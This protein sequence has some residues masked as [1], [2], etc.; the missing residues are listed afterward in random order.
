G[1]ESRIRDSANPVKDPKTLWF[2][3]LSLISAIIP[4]ISTSFSTFRDWI[5]AQKSRPL[6]YN[7]T[8]CY[9]CCILL[10]SLRDLFKIQNAVVHSPTTYNMVVTL[11]AIA[12]DDHVEVFLEILFEF[13]FELV[14][15]D[16]L[17]SNPGFEN[18]LYSTSFE[19]LL[20]RFPP[21]NLSSHS[22]ELL[23]HAVTDETLLEDLA[24]EELVPTFVDLLANRL[25][26]VVG[27]EMGDVPAPLHQFPLTCNSM[28]VPTQSAPHVDTNPL[29]PEIR[30][31]FIPIGSGIHSNS[32]FSSQQISRCNIY[33]T[34]PS[35]G[36]LAPNETFPTYSTIAH[37]NDPA[38]RPI[39]TAVKSDYK[40]DI[41]AIQRSPKSGFRQNALD[42]P[43]HVSG[44]KNQLGNYKRGVHQGSTLYLQRAPQCIVDSTLTLSAFVSDHSM[45]PSFRKPYGSPHSVKGPTFLAV[46][47]ASERAPPNNVN[48]I[49]PKAVAPQDTEPLHSGISLECSPRPMITIQSAMDAQPRVVPMVPYRLSTLQP[50]ASCIHEPMLS[51]P[52]TISNTSPAGPALPCVSRALVYPGSAINSQIPRCPISHVP[53]SKSSPPNGDVSRETTCQPSDQS[54]RWSVSNHLSRSRHTETTHVGEDLLDGGTPILVDP[55]SPN[56]L[57]QDWSSDSLF[58]SDNEEDYVDEPKG[59]FYHEVGNVEYNDDGASQCSE[60]FGI[61][62][63]DSHCTEFDGFMDNADGYDDSIDLHG[64]GENYDFGSQYEYGDLEDDS[65]VQICDIGYN[66]DETS[67]HSDEPHISLKDSTHLEVDE[68]GNAVLSGEEYA[69]YD[70]GASLCSDKLGSP[71]DEEET[72]YGPEDPCEIEQPLSDD[73]GASQGS[74]GGL[75][76][77]RGNQLDIDEEDTTYLYDEAAE[78]SDSQVFD[79]TG[80]GD[81]PYGDN[82]EPD[83][84]LVLVPQH[85]PQSLWSLQRLKTP[86]CSP[87]LKSD[88]YYPPMIQ[89]SVDIILAN[90]LAFSLLGF[91]ALASFEPFLH[92]STALFLQSLRL[93]RHFVS[94][95]ESTAVDVNYREH[96]L[97]PGDDE[98]NSEICD[99]EIEV[100][101]DAMD[102]LFGA[103]AFDDHSLYGDRRSNDDIS[104]HCDDLRVFYDHEDEGKP[105][106]RSRD[107]GTHIALI[108]QDFPQ[109]LRSLQT[110]KTRKFDR[111]TPPSS[112]TTTFLYLHPVHILALDTLASLG[113]TLQIL[114]VAWTQSHSFLRKEWVEMFDEE[115]VA[116]IASNQHLEQSSI[117]GC[118]VP[119]YSPTYHDPLNSLDSTGSYVHH[120]HDANLEPT[121]SSGILQTQQSSAVPVIRLLTCLPDLVEHKQLGRSNKETAGGQRYRGDVS[122]ASNSPSFVDTR[123]TNHHAWRSVLIVPING[124]KGISRVDTPLQNLYSRED[125]GGSQR[126]TRSRHSGGVPTLAPISA[127]SHAPS[128][129]DLADC[130][131]INTSQGRA[132][133]QDQNESSHYDRL[134][135]QAS[136][137]RQLPPSHVVRNTNTSLDSCGITLVALRVVSG[138]HTRIWTPQVLGDRILLRKSEGLKGEVKTHEPHKPYPHFSFAQPLDGVISHESKHYVIHHRSPTYPHPTSPLSSIPSTLPRAQPILAFI[139]GSVFGQNDSLFELSK[140]SRRTPLHSKGSRIASLSRIDPHE[141]DVSLVILILSPA[142]CPESL[143]GGSCSL[144]DIFPPNSPP[145]IAIDDA[146][147]QTNQ[148]HRRSSSHLFLIVQFPPPFARS[149]LNYGVSD[150]SLPAPHLPIGTTKTPTWVFSTVSFLVVWELPSSKLNPRIFDGSSLVIRIETANQDDRQPSS[151]REDEINSPQT[152]QLI[153]TILHLPIVDFPQVLP[154]DISP[155]PTTGPNPPTISS[156]PQINLKLSTPRI[157]AKTD[158]LQP[159]YS[160]RDERREQKGTRGRHGDGVPELTP[161]NA[162]QPGYSPSIRVQQLL[163]G[164]TGIEFEF[165][166]RFFPRQNNSALRRKNERLNGGVKTPSLTVST[167]HLFLV[168]SPFPPDYFIRLVPETLSFQKDSVVGF[169]ADEN[170]TL[171]R[172]E[173]SPFDSLVIDSSTLHLVHRLLIDRRDLEYK[174]LTF[175]LTSRSRQ[176]SQ[177]P[178]FQ[179]LTL[180][181]HEGHLVS[182]SRVSDISTSS[183][184]LDIPYFNP[185]N[186]QFCVAPEYQLPIRGIHSVQ[187]TIQHANLKHGFEYLF[188]RNDLTHS[189]LR[190]LVSFG[191]RKVQLSRSSRA[192]PAVKHRAWNVTLFMNPDIFESRG[193]A[194]TVQT[195]IICSTQRGD[196]GKNGSHAPHLPRP[197]SFLVVLF[198]LP[199]A[200]LTFDHQEGSPPSN[201]ATNKTKN[202]FRSSSTKGDRQ[203]AAW[204]IL[205]DGS[206]QSLHPQIVVDVRSTGHLHPYHPHYFPATPPNDQPYVPRT[207]HLVNYDDKITDL[208]QEVADVLVP[209]TYETRNHHHSPI[210]SPSIALRSLAYGRCIAL[211]VGDTA[212]ATVSMDSTPTVT[213]RVQNELVQIENSSRTWHSFY[214]K[215]CNTPTNLFYPD[216]V[217]NPLLIILPYPELFEAFD[218]ETAGITV[219][220]R[221]FEENKLQAGWDI[222]ATIDSLHP[223]GYIEHLQVSFSIPLL[224]LSSLP[225]NHLLPSK[226]CTTIAQR[227]GYNTKVVDSLGLCEI[228]HVPPNMLDP[229]AFTLVP[230]APP[231]TRLY[232]PLKFG[233]AVVIPAKYQ[234]D[235]GRDKVGCS[236]RGTPDSSN[237]PQLGRLV[238]CVAHI[239]ISLSFSFTNPRSFPPSADLF[240]FPG[241]QFTDRP[242]QLGLSDREPMLTAGSQ[243]Y[244]RNMR[245]AD[246]LPNRNLDPPKTTVAVPAVEQP[247]FCQFA[248]HSRQLVYG[249]TR[250]NKQASFSTATHQGVSSRHPSSYPNIAATALLAPG[251]LTV[252]ATHVDYSMGSMFISILKLELWVDQGVTTCL[253]KPVTWYRRTK[254][255]LNWDV[256]NSVPFLI[257]FISASINE[258]LPHYRQIPPISH[259]DVRHTSILEKSASRNAETM[260]QRTSNQ[261]CAAIYSCRPTTPL[262]TTDQSWFPTLVSL[263]TPSRCIK[264]L[265][266]DR[267][268]SW[269]VN[270]RSQGTRRE[271]LRHGNTNIVYCDQDPFRR[272]PRHKWP[273]TLSR[274]L[275][276]A[277]RNAHSRSYTQE[278]PI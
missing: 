90:T 72:A 168:S 241:S 74:N 83:G 156:G 228:N 1:P 187:R 107:N 148:P 222:P 131:P 227:K 89:F 25:F 59:N 162:R 44:G 175:N 12:P 79:E 264:N 128:P 160:H 198:P 140:N 27:P 23:I 218:S 85:F 98:S 97:L 88:I 237:H 118:I 161:I 210:T 100:T 46:E 60:E 246:D 245:L 5:R 174:G 185:R 61:L 10:H 18:I 251:D 106:E 224:N 244:G 130:F 115:A 242:E 197:H 276:Y 233:E 127:H 204:R 206:P 110:P 273:N 84:Y 66:N 178:Y 129:S 45:I 190:A 81:S 221:S 205:K 248:T 142:S 125:D 184:P 92:S 277:S 247:Q 114:S 155:S 38:I 133:L 26:K 173:S 213:L 47:K 278:Q 145:Q 51:Q 269:T 181:S 6:H 22:L 80:S 215:L 94:S 20:R 275:R 11:S 267:E 164:P 35:S 9:G 76:S 163:R 29:Y 121:P 232:Q 43:S 177:I 102:D 203:L 249:N 7:R 143:R 104:E 147:V 149:A 78:F 202:L 229:S 58:S 144:F 111:S 257:P 34:V 120:N 260:V 261:G 39:S 65:H 214:P 126:A 169:V 36:L 212:L 250:S 271:S 151:T 153:S 56:W 182:N 196:Q 159:L 28:L 139:D 48:R 67:Q 119:V 96:L 49:A 265:A 19:Q 166:L 124:V 64:Y 258:V 272:V 211:V 255:Q 262:V 270:D 101:H 93:T 216:Q 95:L 71:H 13:G 172:S 192:L 53:S 99:E 254:G 193:A 195:P 207:N 171:Q 167:A 183:I 4:L 103:S 146:P 219:S 75:Y 165:P 253:S 55:S 217:Y 50:S 157:V 141:L 201:V 191:C 109:S 152:S 209:L 42:S 238:Q 24:S 70:D 170:Q 82:E 154:F 179:I 69:E 117:K 112:L 73:D 274:T 113:H 180:D 225:P 188:L 194:L 62:P 186:V 134:S 235:E 91:V 31:A 158:V 37:G 138:Q 239:P 87:P 137:S 223:L 259:T 14:D 220:G 200:R 123:T 234:H 63:D 108:S 230:F 135:S 40:P 231:S 256:P 16:N 263:S 17:L 116:N 54:S 15:I 176:P 226:T 105:D 8:P 3:W 132:K 52:G 21:N 240:V 266:D 68:Q 208:P 189:L 86:Y 122:M 150:D 77:D 136:Q 243:D 268:E 236:V 57:D 2:Y 199:F 252:R 30:S 32:V 41:G 33:H